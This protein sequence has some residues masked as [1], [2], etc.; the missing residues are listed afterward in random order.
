MD[1]IKSTTRYI[2]L[3]FLGLVLW[4]C[5]G[6]RELEETREIVRDIEE[7]DTISVVRTGDA[8]EQELEEF[9]AWLNRQAD[10]GDTA[11]RREWPEIR[12]E[13]RRKNAQLEEQF[14]SLSA[15]SKEE[16]RDLQA[17]YKRWEERQERRQQLPLQPALAAEWQERLL[18]EYGNISDIQPENIREAYLTF[19]GTVRTKRRN[20]TQ[21]D[22]DYVDYVYSEL[23]Q[24]RR[25][26][27]NQVRTAD[28]LKI[29]TL[30]AEYLALEGSADTQDM[31]REVEE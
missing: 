22:W 17:R 2:A 27:Q 19:M 29:R 1:K 10:K 9:R 16:F 15:E 11:I 6:R 3:L 28:K 21:E 18:G 23:N 12:E 8:A 25:E 31:L 24:R 4:N 14:D 30:Q 5:E 20:W 13:L 7:A 26:I